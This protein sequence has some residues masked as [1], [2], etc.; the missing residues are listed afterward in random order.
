MVDR[1]N[2][3]GFFVFGR[4]VMVDV[5]LMV[6][7]EAVTVLVPVV[8]GIVLVDCT[9]VDIAVAVAMVVVVV[10]VPVVEVMVL[11]VSVKKIDETGL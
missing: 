11:V 9:I 6:R 8:Q 2:C 10:A 3:S 1:T 5:V 7:V 4:G